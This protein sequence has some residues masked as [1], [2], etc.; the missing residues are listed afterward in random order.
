MKLRI[1]AFQLFCELVV[2]KSRIIGHQLALHLLVLHGEVIL[3]LGLDDRLPQ[4]LEARSSRA[5]PAQVDNSV[6]LV[7]GKIIKDIQRTP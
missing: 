5:G 3:P 4:V 1:R 2:L 6:N 7:V